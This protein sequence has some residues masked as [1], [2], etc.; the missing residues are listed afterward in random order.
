VCIIKLFIIIRIGEQV[1]N[2]L[3]LLQIL[4]LIMEPFY[5]NV[6]FFKCFTQMLVVWAPKKAGLYFRFLNIPLQF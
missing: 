6:A 2:K 5:M 4:Y 3:S 1:N